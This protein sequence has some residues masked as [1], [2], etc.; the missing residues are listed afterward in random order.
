MEAQPEGFSSNDS[1]WKS[2]HCVRQ[3]IW[4]ALV[5]WRKHLAACGPAAHPAAPAAVA[6]RP[7]VLLCANVSARCRF[8]WSHS[9]IQLPSFR[10]THA[11]PSHNMI[12]HRLLARAGLRSL[13]AAEHSGGK[14]KASTVLCDPWGVLPG[15]LAAGR[16]RAVRA[17]SQPQPQRIGCVAPQRAQWCGHLRPPVHHAHRRILQLL[18]AAGRGHKQQPP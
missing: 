8:R 16:K 5:V 15:G 17:A 14:L 11:R 1:N 12:S 4:R 2:C 3:P 9:H 13:A 18:A 7:R 10:Q 6:A